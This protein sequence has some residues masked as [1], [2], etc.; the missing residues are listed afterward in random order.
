MAMN[1][2]QLRIAKAKLVILLLL[3]VVDTVILIRWP[4]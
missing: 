2:R 4:T 3:A 1:E